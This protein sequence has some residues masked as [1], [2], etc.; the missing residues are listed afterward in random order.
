MAERKNS[1]Q[2]AAKRPGLVQ[3][4]VSFIGHDLWMIELGSMS[5]YRAFV[6]RGVRVLV[7]AG[8]E[9][10][11]NRCMQ[12]AKALTYLTIFSLPALLAL[13]FSAAKGLSLF[14]KLKNGPIDGFM[15]HSFPSSAGE[16]AEN[17]RRIVDDLFHYVE[18]AD[19]G[20]LGAVGVFF[21]VYA[22][23]KMLGSVE[24]AFN[25]IWGVK[26]ARTL[27]RKFTDYLAIVA[28]GP[29]ALLMGTG[30]TGLLA[31]G[32]LRSFL[33]DKNSFFFT[34]A[35]PVISICLGMTLVLSTLP[36]TR[37]RWKPALVGGLVAGLAWQLGQIIFVKVQIGLMS[38]NPIFSSFAAVPLLLSWIYLSWVTLFVGC[39]VSYALQNVEL[40]TSV[41]RTGSVDQRFRETL[42]PRLVWRVVAR[43]MAGQKPPT[44]S[45]LSGELGLGPRVLASVLENLVEQ[46]VLAES[47]AA[48][49]AAYLP[50]RDPSTIR[51]ADVLAAM[52]REQDCELPR[53]EGVLDLRADLALERLEQDLRAS[54]GNIS[55]VDLVREAESSEA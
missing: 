38:H 21:L 48:G 2:P 52:R 11:G 45:E 15:E 49:E 13:V 17:I 27:L 50:A 9:F 23:L 20:P 31:S 55:M 8:R 6:T 43:F 7:I 24:G 30:F 33:G 29:L 53:A 47:R 40:I 26:R 46:Q 35:I 19:L 4:S 1:P 36:N 32:Q 54:L 39:E 16:G 12:H 3:R 25:Q 51:L 22:A 44:A 34:W 18:Q 28:V 10:I 5:A 14:E 41:A 42:A 37:V